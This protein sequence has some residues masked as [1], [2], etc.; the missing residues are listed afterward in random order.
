MKTISK[1]SDRVHKNGILSISSDNPF[2][3]MKKEGSTVLSLEGTLKILRRS[4]EHRKKKCSQVERK[5]M[6][7][8]V[9]EKGLGEEIEKD[10][11]LQESLTGKS[12]FFAQ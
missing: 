7:I 11:A 6:E 12:K 9:D 2:V 8:E 3:G 10:E 1:T 4:I 5:L